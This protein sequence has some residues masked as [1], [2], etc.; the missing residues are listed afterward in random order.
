MTECIDGASVLRVAYRDKDGY[1]LT[2]RSGSRKMLRASRMIFEECF[3]WSPPMVCHTCDNPGCVNPEHL[4]AGDALANNQD[5]ARKG[6]AASGDS[7]RQHSPLDWHAVEMI[8]RLY[9]Q[10][11]KQADLARQFG[12][13]Q[14]AISNIVR[15][16]TWVG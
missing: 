4:F 1:Y 14:P 11:H 8:R 10:G 7:Q 12:V 6:R 16:K 2:H 3:G 15:R 5:K 9:A 13:Q